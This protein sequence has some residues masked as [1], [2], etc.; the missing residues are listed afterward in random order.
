[1]ESSER[2]KSCKKV[3]KKFAI[4][5]KSATFASPFEK[6]AS[7]RGREFIEKVAFRHSGVGPRLRVWK[8]LR[9][10]FRKVLEVP[11]KA[12]PLQPRSK[13]GSL[14][15]VKDEFCEVCC[16]FPPAFSGLGL[17]QKKWKKF[18][19]LRKKAYLCTPI[20][21]DGDDKFIEKTGWST[22]K[23]VPRTR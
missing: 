12:L 21:K 23:Q 6:R 13:N 11:G 4:A 14:S 18:W 15:W 9:K 16:R 10:N 22:R 19:R 8:K 2:E 1:M 20:R 3:V 5:I 7:L 17:A